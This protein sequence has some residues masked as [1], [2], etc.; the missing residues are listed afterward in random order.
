ASLIWLD[1]EKQPPVGELRDWLVDHFVAMLTATSASDEQT[2]RVTRAALALELPDGAAG[3]LAR[4]VI[5]VVA[6]ASHLL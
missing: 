5:P 3:R 6:D 1:E 2:A 4:A